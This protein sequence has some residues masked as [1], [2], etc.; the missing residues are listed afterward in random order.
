MSPKLAPT[1]FMMFYVPVRPFRQASCSAKCQYLEHWSLPKRFKQHSIF[2]KVV[3]PMLQN[4][5]SIYRWMKLNLT[6]HPVGHF[7]RSNWMGNLAKIF[8]RHI[9][10]RSLGAQSRADFTGGW[11]AA[12]FA[13]LLTISHWGFERFGFSDWMAYISAFTCFFH[14]KVSDSVR[15]DGVHLGP[16]CQHSFTRSPISTLGHQVL[17]S[18]HYSWPQPTNGHQPNMKLVMMV[19]MVMFACGWRWAS[20]SDQ[21]WRFPGTDWR[22]F[23]W[24]LEPLHLSVFHNFQSFHVNIFRHFPGALWSFQPCFLSWPEIYIDIYRYW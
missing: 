20:W 10:L 9:D 12:D 4:C 1:S 7:V 15:F 24:H 2:A 16:S 11:A 23:F 5:S 18:S 14:D 8:Q 13:D 22:F 19:M 21:R 3:P 17:N 6:P